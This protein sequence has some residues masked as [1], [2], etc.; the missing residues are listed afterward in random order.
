MR[1][2][3]HL[4]L[5]A[6]AAATPPGTWLEGE[7]LIGIF[8]D[9]A[10]D[11][12]AL[13]AVTRDHPVIL[14]TLTGHAA[15]C[16]SAALARAGI[17]EDT[18]DPAGGRFERDSAGRLTGVLREY[19][20]MALERNVT[21][22]IPDAEAA[23][24]LQQTLTRAAAWGVTSIQDMSNA[25]APARAVSLLA[26]LPPSI[27][28]RVMRM[29]LTTPQ[30]RDTREGR[31]PPRGTALITVSGTKWMLDGVPLEFTFDPRGSHILQK[32]QGLEEGAR[33]LPMTFPR[34]ELRAM[35][36]E[37]R[38]DHDQL[39]LHVSGY[40]SAA[41]MLQAMQSE[42]DA[43]V[44]AA[45]RVRFEHGDGLFP[46]LI[47]Q[48]RALGIVV[49]QNPTHFAVLGEDVQK[50]AQPVRTLIAAGV[51]VAFGSDGPMNPYLNIMLAVTHPH[52][53]SE[54]ITREQAVIAYTRTSAYAEFAE[55]DKGTLEPGKLADLAVLSQDIFTVPLAELPKTKS[56]L[57]LVGGR[58]VYDSAGL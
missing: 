12:G 37:T 36:R 41:A 56:L 8:N 14:Q 17:G 30:G 49:V 18:P 7:I 44:W 42:G 35:L 58:T 26:G 47:P 31:P 46:D 3:R 53:H 4:T 57:T 6:A 16:N 54:G 33:T 24:Q 21:D 29:P 39:L 5:A 50:H 15:I 25:F 13:D 40:P 22:A 51:P 10:V 11:R 20:V 55:A 23:S 52:Q 38:A 28:V 34:T 2:S 48:A 1:R 9:P 19:A 32:G 45:R 43:P 27:R